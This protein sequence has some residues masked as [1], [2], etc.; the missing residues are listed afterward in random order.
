M[1]I[2]PRR[3]RPCLKRT[4]VLGEEEGKGAVA[5]I[6]ELLALRSSGMGMAQDGSCFTNTAGVVLVH[7]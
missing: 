7:S 5:G 1:G 2:L 6:W 3:P 4:E